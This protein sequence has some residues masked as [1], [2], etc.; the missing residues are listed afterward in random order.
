MPLTNGNESGVKQTAYC[1]VVYSRGRV[2][3]PIRQRLDWYT[4]AIIVTIIATTASPPGQIPVCRVPSKCE[5]PKQ[6]LLSLLSE[7]AD[8]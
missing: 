1:L 2:S 8:R 3:L 6:E 7:R 5:K 4:G